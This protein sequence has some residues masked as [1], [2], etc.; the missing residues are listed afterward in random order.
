MFKNGMFW[1]MFISD[2]H[3]LRHSGRQ[4]LQNKGSKTETEPAILFMKN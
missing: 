1:L 3:V 4:P 2:E